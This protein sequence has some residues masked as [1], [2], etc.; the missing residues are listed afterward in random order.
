MGQPEHQAR[1]ALEAMTDEHELAVAMH[2]GMRRL[3]KHPGIG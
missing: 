1:I 3:K 2:R